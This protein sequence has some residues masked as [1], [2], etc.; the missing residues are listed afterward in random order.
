M[1]KI[2][3]KYHNTNI[4]EKSTRSEKSNYKQNLTKLTKLSKLMYHDDGKKK[5]ETLKRKTNT[6]AKYGTNIK[7][8]LK[9]FFYFF[10]PWLCRTKFTRVQN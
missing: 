6:T 9:E 4:V 2:E 1:P 10:V 8:L 3:L 7:T 5:R